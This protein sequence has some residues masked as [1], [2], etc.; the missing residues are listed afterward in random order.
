MDCDQGRISFSVD[1]D[2]CWLRLDGALG[3]AQAEELRRAAVEL[4]S[5][6][7]DVQV[8]WCNATQ[9]DAGIAQVLLS[10][11]GGLAAA[12]RTLTFATDTPPTIQSWLN[13][14]GLSRLL[15]KAGQA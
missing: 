9:I 7:K 3:V 15:Q 11:Q 13:V 14:A 12:G 5:H 10:L 8:D 6:S 1:S 2:F 4:C